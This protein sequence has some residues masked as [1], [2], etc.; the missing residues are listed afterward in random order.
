MAS[1]FHGIETSK[2]ALSTQMAL[3]Q[4]MGHNVANANTDG[5]SRQRVN[6]SASRPI[7]ALGFTKSNAAGQLGTGVQY[8]SI[9][10]VRDKFLD[11]Q[12]RNESKDF[13]SWSVQSDTLNKL[14]GII[15]EP[16]DTGIR[17]VLDNFWKAWSDLSQNPENVTGRKVVRE[18][19]M[20]LADAFNYTDKKLS[21]LSSD[22]TSNIEAKS[23]QINSLTTAIANL[24]DVIYRQEGLGDDANDWRDQRDLLTD[25]LSQIV[26][27]QVT[28]TPQG[29]TINMGSTNLVTFDTAAETTADFLTSAVSSGDVN[30]GEVFGIVTARDRY[31]ADYRKQLDSLAN[32]IANG[33]VQITIPKG[34]VLPQGTVLNGATY[35]GALTSDITVTVQGLNGLQKLGYTLNSPLQTGVDFFTSKDGSPITASNFQL[36]KI[37]ADDPGRIATSM[38]S[39]TTAA[40]EVVVKGNNVLALITSQLKD[41]SFK[42]VSTGANTVVSNGTVDDFF[43][44]VVGQLGV[45]ASEASRNMNNQKSLVD[46]I[47]SQKMSVSGVSIDEEMSNMIMYQH[48]YSAA[49]RAMTTFDQV[50]DKVINNMGI[51]GR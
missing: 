43:R 50:L 49:A 35:S 29:Y 11:D 24:N 32:T 4:T 39:E 36:N 12:F 14:E 38:R 21:D 10:R 42:F 40:G 5:Y 26:N 51:V 46:H 19:A 33:E 31:V 2:R 18:S 34:S 20:A 17:T 7:E 22:L 13:G 9:T 30:S 44:A 16:S 23:N 41:S 28:D 3:M 1:T 25:Q 47:A 37:I 6:I 45:Q 48:A 15:N 27:I 8:D